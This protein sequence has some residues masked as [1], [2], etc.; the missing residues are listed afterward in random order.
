MR[1]G[2]LTLS[3]IAGAILAISVFVMAQT[4]WVPA[5]PTTLMQNSLTPLSEKQVR[6]QAELRTALQAWSSAVG[7]SASRSENQNGNPGVSVKSLSDLGKVSQYTS[8]FALSAAP[9]VEI[10]SSSRLV[11]P[12]LVNK[13][14]VS[15]IA[16]PNVSVVLQGGS[17]ARAVINGSLVRVGDVIADG[18]TVKSIMTDAVTFSSPK[19]DMVIRIPLERLRVLGA[20]PSQV[21]AVR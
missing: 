16:L 19:E 2:A 4:L 10:G 14:I 1:Y 15:A 9:I 11:R 21:K 13:D 8:I 3:A 17:E 12:K 20:F 5:R 6:D 18:L 7:Q